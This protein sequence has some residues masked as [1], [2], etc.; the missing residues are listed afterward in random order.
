MAL[1]FHG[2]VGTVEVKPGK[3]RMRG[4]WCPI[5]KK[6]HVPANAKGIK[7][8]PLLMGGCFNDKAEAIKRAKKLAGATK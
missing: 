5:G 8:S 1:K 2:K 6:N 4:R 7:K 3:G